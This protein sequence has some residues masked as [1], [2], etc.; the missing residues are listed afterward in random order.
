MPW[1]TTTLYVGDLT[2]RRSRT[3]AR[4]RAAA[5]N[6]FSS[7][8]G[9]STARSTSSRIARTGGTCTAG[10]ARLSRLSPRCRQSSRCRCGSSA[11]RTTR[12]PATGHAIARFGIGAVDRLGVVDLRDG[13]VEFLNL[14]FVS[15]TNVRM[16][17]RT[18]V[19]AIAA[20]PFD[21]EAVVERRFQGRHAPDAA[22]GS[23]TAP[24]HRIHFGG[25]ADRLSDRRRR[26]RAR[27]L[28]SAAQSRLRRH[29]GRET[30][31][32]REGARRS[33][34]RLQARAR[35][36]PAVL[37]LARFRRR[38][39]QP[40]RQRGLRPPLSRGALRTVGR[41]RR[42]RHGRGGEVSRDPGRIDPNRTAIRGGSAGGYT[43]LSA[44]AFTE[45]LQGRRQLLRRERSRSRSRTTRTSSRAAI[46][47]ASSRLTRA[48]KRSTSSARRC[49]TSKAS[50]P[51]SSPS[52]AAKTR[53]SR[54]SNR[55]QI[56]AALRGKGV[57]VEYQEF[58]GEQHGFRKA[59]NIIRAA[60]AEL[61][62][63]GRIFGFTPADQRPG[64]SRHTQRVLRSALDSARRRSKLR[65]Q[66]GRVIP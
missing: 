60:E 43:T 10:M 55:A 58:E 54:P 7:R 63:Y 36:S 57:P 21:E 1:D 66:L 24:R 17:S 33:D 62:F 15:F 49:I 22:H 50:A 29:A 27:L 11:I 37:D 47:T 4:S 59:E 52:R 61:A 20:S 42:R 23:R 13:K 46:S 28:L 18:Q 41:R 25:R 48:T 19:L 31:A 45:H 40:S 5:T 34:Q 6:P 35:R 9:M 32:A 53:S 56:V 16:L 12:S 14:P 2:A 44:L 65:A 26:H 64:I 8:T 3:C 51:R 38:G 39:R 30:T